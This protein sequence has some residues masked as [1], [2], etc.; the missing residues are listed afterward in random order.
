MSRV[1]L[2]TGAAR[3]LGACIAEHL[4][5]EGYRVAVAD[6]DFAAAQSLV[7]VWGDKAFAVQMDV[8]SASSVEAGLDAVE[9]HFGLPWLLVNNAAIMKAQKV[10]DIDIETFDAVMAVNVRGTFLGCQRFARRLREKNAEGRIVNIGSLAGENGGTATGAHYA[11]SKGAIHTL[12]KVFARDLAPFGITVNT[13]APGPLDLPSV[14]E[15]IGADRIAG[16]I[17]ALPTGRLGDPKTVARMV[18]ELAHPAAGSM[19]GATIDINSGLY[20]R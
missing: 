18:A 1:A 6:L 12:T 5:S 15:T 11:A 8:A 10:L 13:V 20:M 2:V 3:G 17:A 19:T 7:S 14:A 16:L 9:K 4:L